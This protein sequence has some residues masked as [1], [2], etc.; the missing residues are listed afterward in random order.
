V[1]AG[2][3]VSP[4]TTLSM[5]DRD[6]LDM[7]NGKMSAMQAYTNGKLKISGDVMK[8]QLIQKLFQF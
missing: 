5:S 3:H 1:T 6:F 8:S 4:T 2:R 7:M